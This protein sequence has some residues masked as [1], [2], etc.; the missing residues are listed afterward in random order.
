MPR[1]YQ[2]PTSQTALEDASGTPLTHNL[3]TLFLAAL[4]ASSVTRPSGG[5]YCAA[6]AVISNP[7]TGDAYLAT[8]EDIPAAQDSI[9][10]T[11]EADGVWEV[12]FLSPDGVTTITAQYT[13]AGSATKAAIA[14]GLRAALVTAAADEDVTIGGATVF[15]TITSDEVLTPHSLVTVTEAAGGASVVTDVGSETTPRTNEVIAAGTGKDDPYTFGP[16]FVD[17]L[18]YLRCLADAECSVTFKMEVP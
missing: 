6:Y 9:E 14:T 7:G 13:A 15:I 5:S 16:F 10:I 2:L 8:A 17:D 18:P 3:T 11:T 4:A 12:E 1:I